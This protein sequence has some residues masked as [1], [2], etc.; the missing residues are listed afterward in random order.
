[1]RLLHRIGQ[2]INSNFNSISEILALDEDLSF[3][4]IYTSVWENRL[5]LYQWKQRT[6]RDIYLFVMGDSVGRDNRFDV[7]Q[8][9]GNFCT[10]DQVQT[11]VEAMGCKLGWHTWTH[12]NLTLLP[13]E[14]V[15]KEITPPFP[16]KYFGYPYGNVDDRVAHLVEQAGYEDAWSVVQGNGQRFQRNRPYLN[17]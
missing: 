12:P 6:H 10:W 7:G 9:P 17:W 5:E 16:M 2:R 1:M 3:D 11:M 4:G 14:K 13:D 8:P 15:I